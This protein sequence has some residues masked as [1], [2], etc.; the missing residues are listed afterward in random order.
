MDKAFLSSVINFTLFAGA[1]FYYLKKPLLDFVA[2]RHETL[3]SEVSQVRDKLRSAQE[4]YEE[5]SA[6]LKAID[7]ELASIR[8][9]LQKDGSALQG[10]LVSSAKQSAGAI[11]AEAKARSESLTSEYRNLL[12][13]ELGSRVVLRAES[14]IRERLTG[15][16]RARIRR[17]F[18]ERVGSAS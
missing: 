6:K 17:E 5:F 9:N 7:V 15:D 1:A 11:I 10:R 4:K 8:E 14:L 3:R 2:T 12:R 13:A 16:D 18:S